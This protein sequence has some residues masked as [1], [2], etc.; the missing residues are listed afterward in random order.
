MACKRWVAKEWRLCRARHKRHSYA[1]HLLENGENLS[2]I[3]ELLGHSSIATT[4][5]Y[6]HMTGKVNTRLH[7]NLNGIMSDLQP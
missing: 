4:D 3:K 2:T 6:T 5:I 7:V 1:T